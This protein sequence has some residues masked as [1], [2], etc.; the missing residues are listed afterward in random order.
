M[1]IYIPKGE[2]KDWTRPSKYYDETFNYLNK[3]GIPTI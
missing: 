3:I 2:D 1:I